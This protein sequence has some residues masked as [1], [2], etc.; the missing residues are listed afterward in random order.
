MLLDPL[1]VDDE[2]SAVA[3]AVATYAANVERQIL[4]RPDLLTRI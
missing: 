2:D 1:Q 3:R 4:E